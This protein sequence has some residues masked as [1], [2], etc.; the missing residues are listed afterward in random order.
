MHLNHGTKEHFTIQFEGKIIIT[1]PKELKGK[2]KEGNEKAKSFEIETT[3]AHK[4]KEIY[5]SF[6]KKF[7][8]LIYQSK[9][10]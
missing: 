5:V 4:C 9:V 2:D 7:G 8:S 10:L 6:H 3:I 1:E